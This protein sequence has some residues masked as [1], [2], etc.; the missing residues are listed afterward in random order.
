MTDR[1]SQSKNVHVFLLILRIA[2]CSEF[3]DQLR[4]VGRLQLVD[5]EASDYLVFSKLEYMLLQLGL[6]PFFLDEIE[7][8]HATEKAPG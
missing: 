6:L 5:I 3:M 1:C 2:C 7:R 4:E 8:L